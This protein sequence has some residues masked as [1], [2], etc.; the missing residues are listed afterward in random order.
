MKPQ[1]EDLCGYGFG[2]RYGLDGMTYGHFQGDGVGA[3]EIDGSYDGYGCGD[4]VDGEYAPSHV[5]SQD[6]MLNSALELLIGL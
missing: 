6:E 3:D 4:L 2:G 1:Q 5:L